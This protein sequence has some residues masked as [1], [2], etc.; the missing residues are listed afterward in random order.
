MATETSVL[1]SLDVRMARVEGA[2]PY[3]ATKEDISDL[4]G[5]LRSEIGELRSA[6][7]G[8]IGA[9]GSKID[10][11]IGSLR[12]EMQGDIGAL[13]SKIDKEIGSLRGEMSKMRV[14]IG[15]NRV[16]IKSLRWTMTWAISLMGVGLGVLMFVL[17]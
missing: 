4:R 13:G 8:D 11:E 15:E 6:L 16:E 2:L 17:R 14:E 3:L 12:S 9:L 7:Q 10:G 1:E 5:E